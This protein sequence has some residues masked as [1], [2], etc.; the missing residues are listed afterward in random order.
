[1]EAK[2]GRQGV[3]ELQDLKRALAELAGLG[4]DLRHKLQALNEEQLAL[5]RPNC[6]LD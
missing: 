6:R 5:L 3:K 1:M 4:E 2:E